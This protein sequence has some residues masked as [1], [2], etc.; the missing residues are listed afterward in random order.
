M[1]EFNVLKIRNKA[2]QPQNADILLG[3]NENSGGLP[4]LS[5]I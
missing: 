5:A 3:D 1:N 4:C 2:V